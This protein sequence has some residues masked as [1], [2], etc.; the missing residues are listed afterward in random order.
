MAK[1]AC[2]H[3]LLSALCSCCQWHRRWNET[4]EDW[5]WIPNKSKNLLEMQHKH[6]PLSA[7]FLLACCCSVRPRPHTKGGGYSTWTPQM[8]CSGFKRQER[9]KK[10]KKHGRNNP[11]AGVTSTTYPAFSVKKDECF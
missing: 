4:G 8:G 9:I 7:Y 5:K 3:M 11:T 10:K 2:K 6:V 1:S